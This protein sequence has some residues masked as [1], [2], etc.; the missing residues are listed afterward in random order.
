[1]GDLPEINQQKVEDVL[2]TV[3]DPEIPVSIFDLG[4]IYDVS[5]SEDNDVNIKMT[6]TTP[7]CPEAESLPPEVERKVNK[8]HGVRSTQVEIVWEPTWNPNM[9]TEAAQLQLGML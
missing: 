3:F 2:K 9:M 1:M 5:I 6:L 8:I 7:N 4:L